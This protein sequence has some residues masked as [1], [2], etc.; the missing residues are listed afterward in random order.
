MVVREYLVET[1][2]FDDSHLRTLG[3]GKQ[4]ETNSDAGWG[5]VQIIFYP[6]GAVI[7][8][9]KQSPAAISPKTIPEQPALGSAAST[10]KP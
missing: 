4:A 3:K 5:S 7:P 2:G 10:P 6:S 9:N 1:F 8:P